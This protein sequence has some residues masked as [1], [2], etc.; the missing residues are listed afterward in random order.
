MRHD[1]L[2]RAGAH[3]LAKAIPGSHV[4]RWEVNRR[5]P[6]LLVP[7]DSGGFNVPVTRTLRRWLKVPA[8]YY[9]PPR[10]WSRSWTVRPLKV[11]DYVAAPFPWNVE[12]DDGTGRVRFVGHPAADLPLRVPPQG[13]VRRELGLQEGRAILALLPG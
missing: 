6:D 11:A 10:S 3:V 1:R 4:F 5:K 8:L 13:E 2:D 9:I 7:I 12:G